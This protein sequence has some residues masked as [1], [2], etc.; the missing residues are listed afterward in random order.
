MQVMDRGIR[1][2]VAF[3]AWLTRKNVWRGGPAR[4]WQWTDLAERLL[5]FFR[6]EPGVGPHD[7]LVKASF[8]RRFAAEEGAEDGAEKA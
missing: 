1:R 8:G 2:I 3:R 7:Q 6:P 5:S 4:R